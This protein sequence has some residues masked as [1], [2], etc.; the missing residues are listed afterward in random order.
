MT[1]LLDGSVTRTKIADKAVTRAKL[2]EN[3][4]ENG[5]ITEGD[6]A[7][8]ANPGSYQIVYSSNITGLPTDF[9][10]SGHLFNA[11]SAGGWTIQL[12]ST[13]LGEPQLY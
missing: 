8:Y 3:Y 7:N 4:T 9:K 13:I 11:K 2:V 5:T 12:L 1:N 10:Q 6:L